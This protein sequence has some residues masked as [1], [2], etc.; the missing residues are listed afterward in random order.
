MTTS[1]TKDPRA[2]AARI[3]AR[4]DIV[5]VRLVSVSAEL[6]GQ[7]KPGASLRFALENH[8]TIEYEPGETSFIVRV[9]YE[10]TIDQVA[11]GEK[12]ESDAEGSPV[13]EIRCVQAGLF[14]LEMRDGDAELEQG[15][16]EAYA[17]TTGQFA[18]YPYA[19]ELFASL[20]S[21]IGLPALTLPAFRLAIQVRDQT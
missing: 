5:D 6:V 8:P 10:L 14:T 3:A 4:S 9:S 13:A 21:R 11:E 17:Q 1:V 20:T 15:E 7:Q 18:L 16:L 19:R 2:S 12:N